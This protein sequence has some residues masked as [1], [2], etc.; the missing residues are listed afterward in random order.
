MDEKE[1]FELLDYLQKGKIPKNAGEKYEKWARQFKERQGHIYVEERRLIPRS[2]TTWIMSMFHDNPTSAHQGAESMR[3]Q[4]A[5]RYVWPK[6][7]QQIKE[8]VKTC[9]EC[10]RRGGPK[11]NNVKI[12]N[13]PE[14]IFQR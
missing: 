10:Q 5:K 7:G 6:M 12:T 11:E 4:I 9:W 2:E 1:Y 3:K 8:Y 14:D 13:P